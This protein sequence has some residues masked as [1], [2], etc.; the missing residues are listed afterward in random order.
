MTPEFKAKIWNN[1]AKYTSYS[2]LFRM[3]ISL[4]IGLNMDSSSLPDDQKALIQKYFYEL[5]SNPDGCL[6][7]YQFDVAKGQF[8][9]SEVGE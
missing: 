3:L 6:N 7:Q 9:T 5:D 2:E 1:I 8:R 4:T